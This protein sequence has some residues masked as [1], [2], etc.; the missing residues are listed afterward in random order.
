VK[1]KYSQ[2]QLLF[3]GLI[4]E[5]QLVQRV[6][7]GDDPANACGKPYPKR[8]DLQPSCTF[9]GDKADAIEDSRV[10]KRQVY[11]YQ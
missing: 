2:D 11:R 1:N 3:W 7:L 10:I 4:G 5:V 9:P 6:Y 8:P